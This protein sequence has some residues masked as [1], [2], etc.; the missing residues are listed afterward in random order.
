VI[1]GNK[2]CPGQDRHVVF[3]SVGVRLGYNSKKK[4]MEALT[5]GPGMSGPQGRKGEGARCLGLGLLGWAG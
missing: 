1:R 5:C 2:S 4:G 3:L